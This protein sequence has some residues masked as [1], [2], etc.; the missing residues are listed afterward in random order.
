M[1]LMST[2]VSL[3]VKGINYGNVDGEKFLFCD[4]E[5]FQLLSHHQQLQRLQTQ[6]AIGGCWLFNAQN[7][8]RPIVPVA[9]GAGC[10]TPIIRCMFWM[11][12]QVCW[13]WIEFNRWILPFSGFTFDVN[14]HA[15]LVFIF[16]GAGFKSVKLKH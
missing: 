15:L 8:F 6:S 4:K 10:A 3:A 16:L 5:P 1:K 11:Q 2:H 12:L 9:L 14:T 13:G 7:K